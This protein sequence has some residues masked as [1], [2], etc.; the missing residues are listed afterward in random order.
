MPDCHGLD[1]ELAPLV[2]VTCSLFYWQMQV[3]WPKSRGTEIFSL[4]LET[5]L[6]DQKAKKVD[7]G[8]SED[9]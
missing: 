6:Q 9:L 7:T 2:P 8:R 4:Y 3:T 5:K 1:S